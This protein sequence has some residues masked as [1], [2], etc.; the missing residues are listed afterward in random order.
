MALTSWHYLGSYERWELSTSSP[1]LWNHLVCDPDGHWKLGNTGLD[2][3]VWVQKT[4]SACWSFSCYTLTLWHMYMHMPCSFLHV[5]FWLRDFKWLQKTRLLCFPPSS[6]FLQD[7]MRCCSNKQK[8]LEFARS[9]SVTEPLSL[10]APVIPWT[11][12][13]CQR[14]MSCSWNRSLRRCSSSLRKAT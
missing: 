4:V 1:G 9:I 2:W 5:C 7:E 6:H 12:N 3:W 8:W 13:G 11:A 10:T 14:W